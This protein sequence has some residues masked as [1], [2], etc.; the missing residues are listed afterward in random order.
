M[1]ALWLCILFCL[2]AA[3]VQAH[4]VRPAYLQIT[5]EAGAEFSVNWKQPVLGGKRL[6]MTPQ[7]PEVCEVTAGVTQLSAG[8]VIETSTVNCALDTGVIRIDGL[9]RTLTDSFIEINYLSGETVRALVKPSNPAFD[10]GGDTHDTGVGEY[11]MVGVEHIVMGWDHILF[12]IGLCLL[13]R[14]RQIW[15]VATSFTLAHSL[16][17]VLAAFGWLALPSRPVEILIALSIV[18]LGIEIVRKLSGEESLA[19]RRP[20]LISFFIG[21]LHGCG[22]AGALADI[23]LPKDAELFALVLFNLGI[24]LGQFA[25]IAGFVLALTLI[26]KA[27]KNLETQIRWVTT[28]IIAGIAMYW[29]IDRTQA[30]WMI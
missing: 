15:M 23:G 28:Y 11:L 13:V 22:F 8:S 29:V 10:L 5:Q 9:E 24:E 1:R 12:V 14:T 26:S 16:T 27:S 25:I 6:K 3:A 4:E 18:F 20:Y 21:L 19:S 17:L 7:F 2:S 30:Y